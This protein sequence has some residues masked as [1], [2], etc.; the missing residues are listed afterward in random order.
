M[1][2]TI[3]VGQRR[4]YECGNSDYVR[5]TETGSDD[6]AQ[7]TTKKKGPGVGPAG[8]VVLLFLLYPSSLCTFCCIG[9]IIRFNLFITFVN[10]YCTVLLLFLWV[11][12]LLCY[13]L[14]SF[15]FLFFYYTTARN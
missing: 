6:K 5:G 1:K 14:N 10:S 9:F 12:C 8:P 15:S 7:V 3:L 11:I 2:K 13:Q 4:K